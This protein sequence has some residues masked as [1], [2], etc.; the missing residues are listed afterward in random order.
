MTSNMQ[1]TLQIKTLLFGTMM[2]LTSLGQPA[3]A[4]SIQYLT[5]P[6]AQNHTPVLQ[7]LARDPFNWSA[8]QRARLRQALEATENPFTDI[9]MQAILWNSSSPQ[10]VVNKT[11]VHE[12]DMV[13]GISVTAIGRDHISLRKNNKRHTL[14]FAQPDIDFGYP[15]STT[16]TDVAQEQADAKN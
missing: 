4:E 5:L 13:E 6:Q 16:I 15:P 7:P 11:L 3:Q 2:F 1:G 8:R 12:G 14:F 9:T 10:A